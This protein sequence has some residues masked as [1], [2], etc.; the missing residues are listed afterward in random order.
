MER[1]LQI[2]HKGLELVRG[3]GLEQQPYLLVREDCKRHFANKVK[4]KISSI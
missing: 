3:Q 1:A 4:K 2:Q